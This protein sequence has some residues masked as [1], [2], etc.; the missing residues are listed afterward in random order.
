MAVEYHEG[1]WLAIATAAPVV[2]LAHAVLIERTFVSTVRIRQL[3]QSQIF[4]RWRRGR[5]FAA[6]MSP[7]LIALISIVLT[8]RALGDAL[9]SLSHL[10]DKVR[11]ATNNDRV[12]FAIGL[13]MIQGLAFPGVDVMTRTAER[14]LENL[15]R[16]A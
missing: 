3:A 6:G 7:Y 15:Q 12:F 4:S 11:A 2:M 10:H 9:M 14:D 13:L 1:Y 5:L 16:D 8:S